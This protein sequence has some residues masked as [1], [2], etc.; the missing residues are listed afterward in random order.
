MS[1]LVQAYQLLERMRE[2]GIVLAPFL[3]QQMVL[4][5][6]QVRTLRD[7]QERI[8]LHLG[9]CETLPSQT[10]FF[11]QTERRSAAVEAFELPFVRI[12][13]ALSFVRIFSQFCILILLSFRRFYT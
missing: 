1:Q 6:H 13:F 11:V 7:L 12:F 8:W 2:R 5:I 4:E 9:C 3:E 10:I